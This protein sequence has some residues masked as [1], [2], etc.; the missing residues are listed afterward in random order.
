MPHRTEN[1]GIKCAFCSGLGH[2]K[3][4]CWKKS[5][6][7]KSQSGAANFLEVLLNDEATTMQQLDK[8]CGNENLF[9]Y[10]QVHRRR[11]PVEVAL[12]GTVPS[13][14]AAGEGTRMGRETSVR[15]KILSHFVKGKISITPMETVLMIPGELEHL[16]SLVKLAKRKKDVEAVND[17]V[18]MVSAALAIRQICI[19]K[20]HR[21]K[22]LH[23]PVEINSY[24]VEGLVD[25][26]ASM[27]VMVAVVVRELGMMHLVIGS[28]T[29]KIASGVVT[30]ALGRIDEVPVKVRGVQCA[31][32]FMVV[33][34]DSYDVLLGLDFLMKIGAIVDV[35]W[36]L[37]QVRHGP[38]TNVEVLPLTMVNLLQRMNSK[39]LVQES[40]TIWKNTCTNDDS[41]WIPN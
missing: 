5:K 17:Q 31:M 25:T 40:T 16:E 2:S 39:A 26:G 15:S 24:V 36:G 34:P 35:E 7:G 37:I 19:N 8:L 41:D 12:A 32:T 1:C 13:P 4:R 22:T 28:E 30:Q 9:S 23:L 6:N 29:Y 10:T 11:M 21:S 20:T 38:R 18:S 33:D 3:D 27:S 14:E